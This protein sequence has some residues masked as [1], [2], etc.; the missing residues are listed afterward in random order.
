MKEYVDVFDGLLDFHFQNLVKARVAWPRG[1]VRWAEVQDRLDQHY[2][3]Y[4]S[5][6][7]LLS[8]LDNHDQPRFL[9]EARNR[10]DRLLAAARLQ[11]QQAQPPVIYYGT[12]IGMSQDGAFG[13]DFSDLKCRRMM[14]WDEP[15][16]ALLSEYRSLI[17]QWKCRFA[18]GQPGHE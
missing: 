11:F 3:Q 9:F 10:R 16:A 17:A 14:R 13:G 6:C 8:F 7:S 2:A 1:K 12:E 15:D 4:P 5:E 18:G